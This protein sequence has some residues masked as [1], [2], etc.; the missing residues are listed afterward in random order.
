MKTFYSLPLSLAALPCIAGQPAGKSVQERPNVLFICIDDLRRDL[1]CY[2]GPA[3]TPHLDENG[4]LTLIY[5][6][7]ELPY[8]CPLIEDRIELTPEFVRATYTVWSH[9][10]RDPLIYDLVAMDSAARRL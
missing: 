10:L 9:L 3:L 5:N 8:R 6:D 7:E 4:L 2:G 1:G